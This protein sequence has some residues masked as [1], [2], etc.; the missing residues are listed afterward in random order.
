MALSAIG[1]IYL[2]SPTPISTQPR[3]FKDD[4]HV[5]VEDDSNRDRQVEDIVTLC[6]NGERQDLHGITHDQ[7]GKRNIV[8]C[9]E[10]EYKRNDC[11]RRGL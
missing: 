5:L 3:G 4:Y 9:V 6:A 7:R 8:R 11:V 2:Q 1:F 10:Q